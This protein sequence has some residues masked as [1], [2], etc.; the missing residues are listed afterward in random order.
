VALALSNRG[1]EHDQQGDWAAAFVDYTSIEERY[2]GDAD[3]RIRVSVAL[4]LLGRAIVLSE[5]TGV[6]DAYV[7]P[8]VWGS[9]DRDF[10]LI[11]ERYSSDIDPEMRAVVAIARKEL[12]KFAD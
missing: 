6:S 8:V 5:A 4:A 2:S 11:V 9:L 1:S 12:A 7:D 10:T 3:P